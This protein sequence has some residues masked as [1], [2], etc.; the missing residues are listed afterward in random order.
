MA[1]LRPV[2]SGMYFTWDRQKALANLLKHGVTFGEAATAFADPLCLT[3][4]DPD[5][6]EQEPRLVLVGMS[7]RSRLLVVVH[8][9]WTPKLIRIISA[10]PATRTE[11]SAYEEEPQ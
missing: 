11:R 8:A 3:I 4:P 2:P 6:S 1:G 7:R 10:R 5:H 9:E